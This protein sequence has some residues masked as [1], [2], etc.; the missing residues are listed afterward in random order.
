MKYIKFRIYRIRILRRWWCQT[1]VK[2]H[3][4]AY[5]TLCAC[6]ASQPLPGAYNTLSNEIVITVIYQEFGTSLAYLTII[7]TDSLMVISVAAQANYDAYIIVSR[8]V[9]QL[10]RRISSLRRIAVIFNPAAYP[11]LL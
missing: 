4:L 8:N 3:F 9:R 5:C 11:A 6:N 2:S 1:K 7:Q 10:N